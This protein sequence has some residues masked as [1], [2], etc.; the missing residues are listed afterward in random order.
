MGLFNKILKS[1]SEAE[2]SIKINWIALTSIEQL[3][4]LISQSSL[5]PALIFKHSTRCGIS[6]MALKSFERD[7]DLNEENINLYFLDLLKF[8][9]ISNAI[10]V[11]LNVQ[12]QSPQAIVVKNEQVAY[13]DSH[14][15]ISIDAVK[16]AIE[17]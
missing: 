14:S 7:C 5:K 3:D 9:N 10:S 2:N 13:H 15:Q 8:R 1:T 16:K 6:R 11:K 17:N 12:H 4:A